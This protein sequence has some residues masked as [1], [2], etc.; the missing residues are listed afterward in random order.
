MEIL[1]WH[2]HRSA[3][4][5][6]GYAASTR[7]RRYKWGCDY[8]GRLLWAD[9]ELENFQLPDGRTLWKCASRGAPVALRAAV[10]AVA[11]RAARRTPR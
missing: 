5:L 6:Y 4:Q 2:R 11:R 10:R 8:R 1:E 9:R 7:R 3:R